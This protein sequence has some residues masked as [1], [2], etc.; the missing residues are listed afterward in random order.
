MKKISLFLLLISGLILT[1]CQKEL[2][3][4]HEFLESLD[5]EINPLSIID[6]DDPNLDPLWNFSDP[7]VTTAQIYYGQRVNG[8]PVSS[9]EVLLPWFT[10]GNPINS[11]DSD[12]LPSQGWIL[13]MKDFGTPERPAQTPFFAL[14][15]KYSGVLR[16]FVY[17]FRVRN[18]SEQSK[19]YYV[20]ELGFANGSTTSQSLSF[21]SD[22]D[23]SGYL[24]YQNTKQI[25]LTKKDVSD[26]WLNFDFVMVSGGTGE[27][28][29][30]IY[31]ANQSD[32]TLGSD[33]STLTAKSSV[34]ASTS[35]KS[36][37]G[38][39]IEKGYEF[40]S[41]THSLLESIDKFNG[42][43]NRSNNSVLDNESDMIISSTNQDNVK[44]QAI[45]IPTVTAAI[46]IV[47]AGVGLI[48][49]FF[50]GKK[51]TKNT[52]TT[53]QY[54]GIVR[55][56]GTANI[57]NNLYSIQFHLNYNQPLTA[58][59]YRPIYKGSIGILGMPN[60]IRIHADEHQYQ[61][62]SDVN[63]RKYLS[64]ASGNGNREFDAFVRT[65]YE[66]EELRGK[67]Q[68]TK[69]ET[70]LINNA[71]AENN[72]SNSGYNTFSFLANQNAS[73]RELNLGVDMNTNQ[74][75]PLNAIGIY[76]NEEVS[77]NYGHF[78]Y[79]VSRQQPIYS[80]GDPLQLNHPRIGIEIN[81][82][83]IDPEY[84]EEDS[85]E[86]VIFKAITPKLFYNLVPK[87]VQAG[88]PT[89]WVHRK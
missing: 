38:T 54:S 65:F 57:T 50:G 41:S 39:A 25:V 26:T 12:Y 5:L 78:Y 16:F 8:Q 69:F 23:F 46:G 63:K 32:L 35:N 79:P 52:Q 58:N 33:F 17:N 76:D 74:T 77:L 86:R 31:G 80:M 14:Y 55:T 22:Y 1:S 20:A 21:F 44:P 88:C 3:T 2:E 89:P 73:L 11:Q 83:I 53:L 84:T 51:E 66:N 36:N 61:C 75:V 37:F 59:R 43:K 68:L 82:R 29:L 72:R 40:I 13:Y 70:F 64:I 28:L 18:L 19:T 67:V 49:S 7:A 24:D 85:R 42:I 87:P 48:K 45:G 34:G 4:N 10:A 81:Y 15:N 56:T 47:K 62:P 30:N 27:L 6:Q 9:T 71:H 60:R